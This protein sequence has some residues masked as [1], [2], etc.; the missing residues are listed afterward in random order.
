MS[1]S[2]NAPTESVE[3]QPMAISFNAPTE[4]VGN[5]PFAV[6]LADLNGDGNVDAVVTN[7]TDKTVSIL[8]GDGTGDFVEAGSSPVGVSSAYNPIDVFIGDFN[9]DG[10]LDIATANFNLVELGTPSAAPSSNISILLG[11]GNG[12][13]GPASI[14]GVPEA[15]TGT[16][17][18]AISLG[19]F[20]NDGLLDVAAGRFD[21]NNVYVFSGTGVGTFGHFESYNVGTTTRDIAVEDFNKDGNPDIAIVRSGTSVVSVQLGDGAGG[22]LSATNFNVGSEP[23]GVTA[24]DIDGDGNLDLLVANSSSNN[25]S[26]LIGDGNGNFGAAT[27]FSAGNGARAVAAGYIDSDNDLDLVVVNRDDNNISILL[28]TTVGDT[29][30]GSSGNDRYDVDSTSDVVIGDAGIDTVVS[31]VT[32]TL[33][34]NLERLLLIGDGDIDGTGNEL[35]NNL[36]GNDGNNVLNGLGGQDYIYGYGGNDT[37]LGGDGNDFLFGGTGADRMIGGDGNDQYDVDDAGDVVIENA[38]QGLDTV[39]SSVTYTLG[40]N[41]ERLTLT[42]N[43]NIN[44]TGNGLNNRITGNDGINTLNGGGGVDYIYGQG[45][46][47]TLIGGAGNDFLFGGDG[48]NT[49]RFESSSDGLDRIADFDAT[50]VNP[51]LRD[52]IQISA[53]GFA[54]LSDGGGAS[55]DAAAFIS[56][57]GLGA[58]SATTADHRFIYNTGSGALF[59][60]VDGLGG[61]DGVQIAT[62]TN[63][64]TLSASDIFVIA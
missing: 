28:N 31:T 17:L 60:D 40:D 20:N 46:D 27:N 23:R 63:A 61:S 44:G 11:N 8:L 12:T 34:D 41:L 13:F 33:G 2:F 25:V 45:G 58:T 51:A 39:I 29:L 16:P 52:T 9:G 1:I 56:G 53:S 18:S 15:F 32:Y 4:S 21:D 47:D 22:F 43:G 54:G 37:L 36:T 42:G 62:L 59:F 48:R 6:D 10:K 30:T 57:L 24:S 7:S 5:Q 50:D 64:A 38:N 14:Y 35:D 26:L 55:I 19:D 3:N 49:F